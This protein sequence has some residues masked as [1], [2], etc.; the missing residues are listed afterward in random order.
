MMPSRAKS[1]DWSPAKRSISSALWFESSAIRGRS[2]SRDPALSGRVLVLRLQSSV[3]RVE[4]VVLGLPL[5]L[6]RGERLLL[7]LELVPLLHRRVRLLELAQL[8]LEPVRRRA[9]V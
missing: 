8:E 9:C 3:L 2:C 4:R 7:L 5:A 1:V 6:R